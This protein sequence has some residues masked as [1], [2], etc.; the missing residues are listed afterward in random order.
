MRAEFERAIRERQWPIEMLAK[1]DTLQDSLSQ[2][3]KKIENSA[4]NRS[5][6][7]ELAA[8]SGRRYQPGDQ[9]RFYITGTKKKVS[10]YENS[11][12]IS[13]WDPNARDEN[14]EFYVAKLEEI[15]KKYAEFIPTPKGSD[16]EQGEMLF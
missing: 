11:K 13:E 9:V 8:R 14:V 7:Y 15:A 10:S 1:T 2:Y 16:P 12:L 6:P 3:Q 4:R 5:A